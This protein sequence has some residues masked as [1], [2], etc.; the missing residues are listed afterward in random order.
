MTRPGQILIV[1]DDPDFVAIYREILAG[2]GLAVATAHDPATATA[3]LEA[4]GPD[5]DVVLLDQKL[6]GRGGPDS[7]SR[8]CCW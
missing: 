3:Y 7:R 2:L 6:H 4:H 5:I 1:D 8:R